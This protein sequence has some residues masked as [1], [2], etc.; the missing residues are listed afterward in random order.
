MGSSAPE[1]IDGLIGIVARGEYGRGSKSEHEAV[2]LESGEARYL[3]R[4][5]AGP[6]Y[7]DDELE[8]LV[9]RRVECAGFLLGTTLLA[10]TIRIVD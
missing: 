1:R 10:E 2:Y 8:S 7:G 5:K 9:G 6:A 4:R 3:L